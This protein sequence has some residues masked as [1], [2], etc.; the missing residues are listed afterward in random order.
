MPMRPKC[1]CRSL[2]S[3]RPYS[4]YTLPYLNSEDTSAQGWAIGL[5][6]FRVTTY[7]HTILTTSE[8]LTQRTSVHWVRANTPSAGLSPVSEVAPATSCSERQRQRLRV[9]A[10]PS[11]VRRAHSAEICRVTLPWHVTRRV[12]GKPS[13]NARGC[14][15]LVLGVY[16]PN[17][18]DAAA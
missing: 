5:D 8:I 4:L 1:P 17:R 18:S 2:N 7:G 16:V 10:G 6:R 14:S 3:Q 11:S 15:Y 13:W 12:P 9:A